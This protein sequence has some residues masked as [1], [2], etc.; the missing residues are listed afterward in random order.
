M[1][2]ENRSSGELLF[3]SNLNTHIRQILSGNSVSF[4]IDILLI[5]TYL[6][7]M[8]IYSVP[9]TFIVLAIGILVMGIVVLNTKVLKNLS[10]KMVT[11]QGEVQ[12]YLSEHIYGVSDVKMLGHEDL[13]YQTWKGKYEIQLKATE[14]S[15]IWSSFIQAIS[16]SIHFILPLFLL[17]MGGSFVLNN[18][19]TLGTLIAFNS[20]ATA[21]VMPIISISTSYTDF[22]Y[23]SSYV[24]RLM[25][26]IQSKPEQE[27]TNDHVERELQGE[28]TLENVSFSYDSFSDPV[29]K[30]ISLTIKK[31]EKIALVGP[32]GSGKSTLAKIILGLYK[33][34]NG[35][36]LYDDLNID[37]Y[38]LQS[39]R[40]Q[41]GAVLQESRL[42]NQS[43]QENI[44]MGSKEHG[45]NLEKAIDQSNAH[46]FIESLPLG[47]YTNISEG[48]VNF[49]GGQRQRLILARALISQPKILV[50]D[51]ATSAL[52][53][54][55]ERIIEEKISELSSTRI[56]IA[57][58]LSTIKNA[59]RIIVLENGR[60]SEM[61]THDE[62]LQ[63]KGMYEKLYTNEV[64]RFQDKEIGTVSQ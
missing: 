29:L 12:K 37:Y 61:G 13:I 57:H 43:I 40:T 54:N 15:A 64:H 23:L 26:V 25:D 38:H 50:L 60:I 28:I 20:M 44:I 7:I 46:E 14:K 1:F 17:W 59:D 21:F 2:F 52:D 22:I 8:L 62:L 34:S 30:D 35:S 16:S 49:S 19:I 41:I 39:L 33:P 10:D 48:G 63:K 51:E 58:R 3:R 45:A 11:A 27:Q 56:I 47:L 24:Q 18:S 31:G 53:N 9:L 6:I 5:V 36:V 32:S 42:F 4:F 55:A